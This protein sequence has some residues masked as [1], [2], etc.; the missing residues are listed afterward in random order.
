MSRRWRKSGPSA[1]IGGSNSLPGGSEAGL[2][3]GAIDSTTSR[4]PIRLILLNLLPILKVRLFGLRQVRILLEQ[5]SLNAQIHPESTTRARIEMD[6]A[7][8]CLR[9]NAPVKARQHLSKA[10]A[11]ALAQQLTPMLSEIEAIAANL[12]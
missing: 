6:Y 7:K 8:V 11:A 1:E 9:E 10:R 4:P 5:L 3:P 12:A 2:P